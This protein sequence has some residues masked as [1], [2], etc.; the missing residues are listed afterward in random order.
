MIMESRRGKGMHDTQEGAALLPGHSS[1]FPCLPQ[2]AQEPERCPHLLQ[3]QDWLGEFVL[4][5]PGQVEHE[6]LPGLL[7]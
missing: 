1:T 3:P 5:A 2:Q 7:H 4:V 6:E